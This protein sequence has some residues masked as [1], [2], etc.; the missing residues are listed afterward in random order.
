M[1]LLDSVPNWLSIFDKTIITI[2]TVEYFIRAWAA[3]NP[4]RFIFSFWG[5]IDLLALL[6]FYINQYG[7][8]IPLVI[9]LIFRSIRL[10]RIFKICNTDQCQDYKRS[11]ISSSINLFKDEIIENVINHHPSVFIFRLISPMIL[12]SF[13][14]ILLYFS[15]ESLF[16]IIIPSI[17]FLSSF[18]IYWFMWNNHNYDI[19][20]ITNKRLIFHDKELFGAKIKDFNYESITNIA[21]S[22][23]GIWNNI[24]GK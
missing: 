23:I 11:H 24:I 20:I 21:P 19:L 3:R 22:N 14:L 1:D 6:P 5:I 9:I 12:N 7:L 18:I 16:S 2:F 10:L 4:F 17:L 15:S 8:E 13:G